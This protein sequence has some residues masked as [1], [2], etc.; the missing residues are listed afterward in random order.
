[1]QTQKG[2]IL[3]YYHKENQQESH[4]YKPN[5]DKYHAECDSIFTKLFFQVI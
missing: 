3:R 4:L 1:M 5:N 2:N